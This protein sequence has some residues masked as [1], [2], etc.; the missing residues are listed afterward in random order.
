MIGK[1]ELSYVFVAHNIPVCV[2]VDL[3]HDCN[4]VDPLYIIKLSF[5]FKKKAS[6]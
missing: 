1:R 4:H 5:F 6:N 3:A 2:S